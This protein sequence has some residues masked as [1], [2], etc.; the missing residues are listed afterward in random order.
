M[1]RICIALTLVMSVVFVSVKVSALPADKPE[2]TLDLSDNDIT[3]VEKTIQ[4]TAPDAPFSV[5][6][7]MAQ[8]L[9]NRYRSDIYPSSMTKIIEA[10][11]SLSISYLSQP[12]D[13]VKCAVYYATLGTAPMKDAN[14]VKKLSEGESVNFAEYVVI[15]GSCF[16]AE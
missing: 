6:V 14:G 7:M 8:V 2:Y 10:E 15:D 1:K 12:S 16:Y 5:L 9:I 11:P 3:L 4:S 13:R